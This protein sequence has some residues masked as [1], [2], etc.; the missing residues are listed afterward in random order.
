MPGSNRPKNQSENLVST[1]VLETEPK[2]NLEVI[3]MYTS[4]DFENAEKKQ[5]NAYYVM[6]FIRARDV[7]SIPFFYTFERVLCQECSVKT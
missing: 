5:Q 2:E 3:D 1:E 6:Q 4:L 7:I